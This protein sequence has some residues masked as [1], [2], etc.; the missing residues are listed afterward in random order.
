M[1]SF[2]VSAEELASALGRPEG[3]ET[4]GPGLTERLPWIASTRD[5]LC[6]EALS[7]PRP[8]QSPKSFFL[9]ALE[10]VGRYGDAGGT[11]EDRVD[12]DRPHV[13][14]G[15]RACELKARDYLDKVKFQRCPPG[16]VLPTDVV[17]KT[18]EKYLEAY[19][20]LTGKTF[21]WA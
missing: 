21:A 13:L 16:P 3:T 12:D 11:A 10:S 15:V 7:R 17:Q 9:P 14:V 20:L 8:A 5:A 19:A 2:H 6:V 4:F 1:A 18:R